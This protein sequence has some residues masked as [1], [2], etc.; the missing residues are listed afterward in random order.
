MGICCLGKA[1]AGAREAQGESADFGS[2][3]SGEWCALQVGARLIGGGPTVG[4]GPCLASNRKTKRGSA[5][6][7]NGWALL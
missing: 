4:T 5:S 7:Y 3:A 2:C 1:L 6:L